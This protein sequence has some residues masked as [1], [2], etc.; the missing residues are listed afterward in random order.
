MARGRR[1]FRLRAG[2]LRVA[3]YLYFRHFPETACR[4]VRLVAR[5]GLG[6]LRHRGAGGGGLLAAAR[7]AARS[8]SGAAHY[9][10]LPDHLRVRVRVARA[11]DAPSVASLRDLPDSRHGGEWDRSPGIHSRA[12]YL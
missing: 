6:S 11:A 4:R 12:E 8:L 10:A 1:V 9:S 5:S 2:Q 7:L 3:V